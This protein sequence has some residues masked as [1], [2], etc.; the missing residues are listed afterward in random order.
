MTSPE[1]VADELLTIEEACAY[2]KVARQT[3]HNWVHRG[4]IPHE[5]AGTRL[6]FRKS[7]LDAWLKREQPTADSSAA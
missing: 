1:Q 6:R 3:I 4:T 2:L 7:D 5:K